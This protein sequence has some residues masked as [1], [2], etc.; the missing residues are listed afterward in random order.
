MCFGIWKKDEKCA[1]C[2]KWFSEKEIPLKSCKIMA[3]CAICSKFI[4]EKEK[5]PKIMLNV[6]ILNILFNF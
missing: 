4:F 1:I 5:H 6:K 2:R 3:K